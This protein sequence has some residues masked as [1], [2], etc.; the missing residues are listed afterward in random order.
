VFISPSWESFHWRQSGLPATDAR[1][2]LLGVRQTGAVDT[3][4]LLPKDSTDVNL[5]FLSLLTSG[6]RYRSIRT[7]AILS[8]SDVAVTPRLTEW[9][10][11]LVAPADLAVSARTISGATSPALRNIEVTVHNV[12]FQ[13]SDSSVVSLS[14][15]DRH[16]RLRPIASAP[17]LPITVGSARSVTMAVNTTNLPRRVTL[18]ATITPAKRAKDLVQENNIAYHSFTNTVP[19]GATDVAVFADGVQ[20]MDGDYISAQPKLLLSV[21]ALVGQSAQIEARL[22]VNDRLA[23]TWNSSAGD[24]SNNATPTFA[25]QLPDGTIELKFKIGQANSLGEVDSLDRLITVNVQRESRIVQMLNYPNPFTNDT[26]FTLTL[27]GSLPPDELVLR[28]FTVAGRKIRELRI[29]S[30][31]LHVGFN[32]IYWDG[33]DEEGDEIANGYYFYQASMKGDGKIQSE[34]QKL[35]KAR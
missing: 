16:N 29:P 5:G 11:D 2:A 1:V 17:M 15:Y 34:I 27:S 22:L 19:S 10:M 30:A 21:P 13:E 24:G 32:R 28:V 6:E 35:V 33:R 20:V 31:S 25:P 23:G 8:T 9:W 18:Q 3:L 7:A 14:V 12:G 4:R 26:Y